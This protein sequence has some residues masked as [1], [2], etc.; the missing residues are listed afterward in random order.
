VACRRTRQR[1]HDSDGCARST[2]CGILTSLPPSRAAE[3]GVSGVRAKE[4]RRKVGSSDLDLEKGSRNS[5]AGFAE[6]SWN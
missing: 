6:L 3:A 2:F 1:G 5:R 4:V